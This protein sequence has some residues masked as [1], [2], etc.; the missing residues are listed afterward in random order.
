MVMQNIEVESID[1]PTKPRNLRRDTLHDVEC[2]LT[3]Q[4]ERNPYFPIINIEHDWHSVPLDQIY[5]AM[6]DYL[7]HWALV[8]HRCHLR[9]PELRAALL[10]VAARYRLVRDSRHNKAQ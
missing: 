7:F 10:K 9:P 3:G 4:F 8:T 2:W 6:L 5:R 1:S